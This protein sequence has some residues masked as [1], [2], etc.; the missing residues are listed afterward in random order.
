MPA[1][2]PVPKPASVASTGFQPARSPIA[3]VAAP[4]VKL[5]STVRSGKLSTRKVRKTPNAM[6]P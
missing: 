1:R 6:T 4:V 5:P 2:N 3:A